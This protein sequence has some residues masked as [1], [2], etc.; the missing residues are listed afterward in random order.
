MK[1]VLPD[2]PSLLWNKNHKSRKAADSINVPRP[3][4]LSCSI[5]YC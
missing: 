2:S 5:A 3:L 1:L 4:A